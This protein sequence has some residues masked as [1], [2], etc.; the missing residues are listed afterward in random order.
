L[1]F[2]HPIRFE[3]QPYGKKENIEIPVHSPLFSAERGRLLAMG[4]GFQGGRTVEVDWNAV[5]VIESFL[6]VVKESQWVVG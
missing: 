4:G 1:F 2:C 3:S 6:R 5:G